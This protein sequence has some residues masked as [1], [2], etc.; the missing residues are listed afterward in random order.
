[1]IKVLKRVG[2][3]LYEGI[4]WLLNTDRQQAMDL[5]TGKGITLKDRETFNKN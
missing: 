4:T 2:V 5:I 3:D 1:M